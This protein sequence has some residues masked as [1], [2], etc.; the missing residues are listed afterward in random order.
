MKLFSSLL[1]FFFLHSEG[2][3]F[4]REKIG[5]DG[6]LYGDIPRPT[7]EPLLSRDKFKHG[8]V[9]METRFGYRRHETSRRNF[10]L[11]ARQVCDLPGARGSPDAA[12]SFPAM[13]VTLCRVP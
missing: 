5:L 4:S 11:G 1:T 6:D 7:P 12:I 9:L 3:A 8:A 10:A 2:L 13:P